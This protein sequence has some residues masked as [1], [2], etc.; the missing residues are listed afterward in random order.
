ML[1]VES[2]LDWTGDPENPFRRGGSA[3]AGAGEVIPPAG[4]EGDRRTRGF[5]LLDACAVGEKDGRSGGEE[6]RPG[7][8]SRKKGDDHGAVSVDLVHGPWMEKTAF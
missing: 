8:A 1:G 6:R 4:W 3:G 2:W 5:C 7:R